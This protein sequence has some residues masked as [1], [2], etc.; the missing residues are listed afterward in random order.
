VSSPLGFLCP[1]THILSGPVFGGQV[2]YSRF[3]TL[4]NWSSET[5]TQVLQGWMIMSNLNMRR[6]RRIMRST[7]L[8]GIVTCAAGNAVASV[9][10]EASTQEWSL[11]SGPVEYRLREKS[12]TVVFEYF[13][14]TGGNTWASPPGPYGPPLNPA[15][16][17]DLA[18]LAEGESLTPQNLKLT[19]QEIRPVQT[20]VD[21]LTLT[22]EHQRLP[23]QIVAR[24]T[25]WAV[26]GVITRELMVVNGGNSLLRIKSLPSLA[27]ELP[28]GQY[29]LTYLWGG[30]SHERQVAMEQ[31][32]PGRRVFV[33]ARG[34]STNGY[35]P[36]F[37]LYNEKLGIRYFAQLAYS[38]NWQMAFERYPS[39][40]Y[41]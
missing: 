28:G 2:K 19:S 16:R 39:L 20:G 40:L 38:G 29:E 10:Y 27:W 7:L 11:Q 31:L 32:G 37:C 8:V 18:G 1:R 36:W 22:F 25:T 12:G 41:S 21:Q 15:P 14:P 34:R 26:T 6:V 5:N 23:L 4:V 30:W 9:R 3:T 13:G 24:Y 17:Y 35:S 33:D